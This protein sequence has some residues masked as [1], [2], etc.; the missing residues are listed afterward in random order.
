MVGG[1]R[2]FSCRPRVGAGSRTLGGACV[3]MSAVDN[4]SSIDTLVSI[5]MQMLF[6]SGRFDILAKYLVS[7]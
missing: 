2:R 5:S 3:Q 1:A 6:S 7:R 4:R